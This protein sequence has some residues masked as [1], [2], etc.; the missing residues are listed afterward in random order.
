[1]LE[2]TDLT[3]AYGPIAAVNGLSLRIDAGECVGLLGPN[4]AGKSSTLQA[5]SNLVPH[6]G[7]ITFDGDDLAR[8]TP[9]AIASSGLIHVPEGRRIYPTLTVQENLLV[10]RSARAGRSGDF[11][12]DEVLDL[13]PALV[14]LLGRG[15]WALSGGEQQ[16]VAIGRA[17]VGSPRLLLLDEPSLGLAPVIAKVVFEALRTIAR[18]TPVLVVEQNTALALRVCN[19]AAVVVGGEILLEGTA[20]DL[21]GRQDLLDS[22]LGQHDARRPP[23]ADDDPDAP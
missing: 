5:I 12:I 2:I 17:L 19:R 22:F 14:P 4:G 7:T 18:T 1:M 9:E 21:L 6:G 10:G 13:F 8:R 23:E 20:A 3:V 11:D 16:M 15:G